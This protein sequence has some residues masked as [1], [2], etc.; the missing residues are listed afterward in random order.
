M[1]CVVNDSREIVTCWSRD[2]Y[3]LS[4]CCKVSRS[5]LLRCIETCALKYYVNTKLTP[6]KLSCVRLSVDSDLLTIND[7][8]VVCCLYSVLA[9]AILTSEATLCCIILKKV[10]QHFWRCKVIDCNYL[11]TICLKHLTESQT[12][13]TAEAVNSNFCHFV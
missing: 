11:I 9:L 12:T 13:D 2:N 10:S 4:T 7:D 8:R 1:V 6:R 5:L 3:L